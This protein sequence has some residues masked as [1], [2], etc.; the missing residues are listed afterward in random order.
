MD[1]FALTMSEVRVVDWYKHH[2]TVDPEAKLP[3]RVGQ[4]PIMENQKDWF[5]RTLDKM[6]V[7]H[8]VQRSQATLSRT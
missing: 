5:Y 3:T 8:I 1:V 2:L 4:R 7:A 6:E